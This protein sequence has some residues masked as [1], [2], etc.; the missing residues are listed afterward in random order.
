MQ[1]RREAAIE[2]AAAAA[3]GHGGQTTEHIAQIIVRVVSVALA[4]DDQRVDNGGPVAGV[5]VPDEQPVLHPEFAGAD[6]ILHQVG[7]EPG[8][9][10]I[11]M[12]G[13]RTPV[14][15]QIRA[16]GR[17][18]T[19]AEHAIAAPG[20]AGATA[21]TDRQSAGVAARRARR[22]YWLRP[23]PPPTRR[24]GRSTAA[25]APPSSAVRPPPR[26]SADARPAPKPLD[27]FACPRVGFV[28]V[29][30]EQAP[31]VVPEQADGLLVP[32]G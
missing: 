21:P 16:P 26:R 8:L 3:S 25:R 7:V 22:R 12:G 23:T 17:G 13:E 5:G 4:G 10:V 29:R 20:P 14:P 6:G 19:L 32:T 27:A 24:D 2:T 9:A 18:R 11:E 31:I 28:A 15:E 30:L 1:P